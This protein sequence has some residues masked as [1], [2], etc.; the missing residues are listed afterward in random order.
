MIETAEIYFIWKSFTP[1]KRQWKPSTPVIEPQF[2]QIALPVPLD[3]KYFTNIEEIKEGKKNQPV[4]TLEGFRYCIDQF[5][6]VMSDEPEQI[7]DESEY[8]DDFEWTK[9]NTE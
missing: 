4:L 5:E 2:V 3:E 8:W 6:K 1:D 7:D 9:A